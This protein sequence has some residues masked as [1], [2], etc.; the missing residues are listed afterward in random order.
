MKLLTTLAVA[1]ATLAIAP[2]G[3]AHTNTTAIQVNGGEFFYKLS[4][5]SIARPGTVT[6]TFKNVGH[7]VHDFKINGK[8]TPLIQPGATARL[9]VVFNKAGKYPYLCTV[10][11]HASAGMRGIFT[12][13]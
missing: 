1:I 3:S 6:F 5:S 4:T 10:P 13:R 12:V 11:E 8:Q 2:L 9:V 7:V